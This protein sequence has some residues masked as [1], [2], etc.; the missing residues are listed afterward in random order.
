MNKKNNGVSF[1]T[2]LWFVLSFFAA[3]IFWLFVEY[4]EATAAL[5]YISSMFLLN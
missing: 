1:G 2:I 3:V 4:S 5:T